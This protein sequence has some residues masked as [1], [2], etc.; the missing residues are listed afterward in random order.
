MIYVPT[1]MMRWA[2]FM[3]PVVSDFFLAFCYIK[4]ETIKAYPG[5]VKATIETEK[6]G[7]SGRPVTFFKIINVQFSFCSPFD[8]LS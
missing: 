8:L 2:E 6:P 3:R 1:Y 4:T 7:G 5:L